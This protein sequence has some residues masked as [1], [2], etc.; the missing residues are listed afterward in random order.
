VLAEQGSKVSI[1]PMTKIAALF[2][3]LSP[4]MILIAIPIGVSMGRRPA[5]IDFGSAD[6]LARLHSASGKVHILVALALAGPVL[7]LGIGP[8][9]YELLSGAG[10]YVLFGIVLW[11]LGMIFVIINDTLEL[12]MVVRLPSAFSIAREQDRPALLVF[13]SVI[14]LAIELFAFVGD[15]VSFLGLGFIAF[16]MLRVPMFPAWIAVVG[17]AA[18][19]LI[20]VS[21]V[22]SATLRHSASV[23]RARLLGFNLF[24][25]WI[26]ST[27]VM[28]WK[29]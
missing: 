22:A 16:A 28:L 24:M 3:F 10:P 25:L 7:A 2:S 26:I 6:E 9:W 12:A 11:Y 17:I 29:L 18:A 5:P 4:L 23:E 14:A 1:V 15:L 21:T 19:I 13:G 20:L 8:G 27:G